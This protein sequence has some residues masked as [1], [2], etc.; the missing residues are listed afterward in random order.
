MA[1][2]R[3]DSGILWG[4]TTIFVALALLFA[5]LALWRA[6]NLQQSTKANF[7]DRAEIV[8]TRTADAVAVN[9]NARFHDLAFLKNAFFAEDTSHLL[10][11][12][13]VLSAFAAFQHTHPAVSAINIQD[14]S[15]DRIVWSSVKQPARPIT[16]DKDFSP[17][18]G[19]PDR[20]LGR[21]AY[22]QRTHAWVF[23]MR[24]RIRDN[25]GHVLGFIGSPFLLANL[26]MIHTP[27]ELQSV[28]VMRPH[29]QV[30]SVWKDG[31]WMPPDT[32]LAPVDGEVVVPVPGYPWDLHVQWTAAAL[33]HA[34]W[35]MERKR[36]PIFL[37]GLFFI[38]GMGPW[39]GRM[40][41]RP[42]T[43]AGG[44]SA[45]RCHD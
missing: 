13:Q 39:A 21:V 10:P 44:G 28:V 30:V 38:A 6:I 32:P 23:T 9:I 12:A 33:N 18:P 19:Y 35:Q 29:G 22:A 8:A 24:Q 40:R 43:C 1:F 2:F 14:P 17:L 42:G 11:S 26:G 20:F 31:R 27:P 4:V 45:P 5:G 7:R 41:M 37:M 16:P 36:L 25:E 34:F 3:S 15:G